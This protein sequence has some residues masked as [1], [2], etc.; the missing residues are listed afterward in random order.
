MT[1]NNVSRLEVMSNM[2]VKISSF[3]LII[4]M[5]FMVSVTGAQVFFRYILNH[6]LSWPEEVNIFMMAWITF[7]GSSV[8]I[9][10][11]KHMGVTFFRDKLP[12]NWQRI[13]VFLSHI[14]MLCFVCVLI[15]KGWETAMEFT[16]VYSD[17]L[18]IP[19]VYAR[20]SIVVGSFMMSFQLVILILKD[21]LLFLG[22]KEQEQ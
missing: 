18:E 17:A 5:L 22:D 11:Q 9:A 19:I 2:L 14:A 1:A 3:L 13:I 4:L 16:E 8:A 7:I 21:A 10:K 6:A 12:S 15:F 20:M